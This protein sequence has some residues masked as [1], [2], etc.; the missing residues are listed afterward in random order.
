MSTSVSSTSASGAGSATAASSTAALSM[1][2]TDFLNL[3][4]TQLRYQNP[5]DPTNATDFAS[6]LAQYASVEQL[7]NINSNLTSSLTSQKTLTSSI[8]NALATTFIG[9]SV[10]AQTDKFTYAGSGTVQVGYDLASSGTDVTV[11]VYNAAGHVVK[12]FSG[13]KDAT[14]NIIKWDGTLSD[15]TTAPA[16]S[17]TF[18]VS[19]TDGSGSAITATPYVYGT[20]TAVRYKSS[21]TVFVIDGTEVSLSDV[22][23]IMQ[24]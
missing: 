21:G 15:G 1:N 18:S 7:S 14:G 20:V 17:Y 6:Q 16:G 23:E 8:N 24:E 19:A 3:L 13:T 4:V 5:L 2:E 12:S 10:R 9:K 22:L 11:N